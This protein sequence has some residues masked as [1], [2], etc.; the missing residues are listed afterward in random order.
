MDDVQHM[1]ANAKEH[2]F[3]FIIDSNTRNRAAYPSP[4]EYYI[5][6]PQPF[7]NVFAVDLIDA[8]IPRTEFSVDVH[9]NVIA[10]APGTYTTYDTALEKQTIVSVRIPPGDY[11]TAT[12]IQAVN[13]RLKFAGLE[14]GHAPLRAIPTSSPVDITN[15]LAFVR[16]EP[17]TLFMNQ[18]SMRSV[19]GFGAPATLPGNNV[20]WDGS[21]R[22][23]TNSDV[24]ND[25]FMSVTSIIEQGESFIGPMPIEVVDFSVQ[26]ESAIRQIYASRGSGVLTSIIIRGLADQATTLYGWI[27]D[28]SFDPPALVQSFE[29]QTDPQTNAWE[30]VMQPTRQTLDIVSI[31]SITIGEPPDTVPYIVLETKQAHNLDPNEL[32][33]ITGATTLALNGR[34][35]LQNPDNIM[36]TNPTYLVIDVASTAIQHP[37]LGSGVVYASKELLE[38]R[39]YSIVLDVNPHVRIYKALAFSDLAIRIDQYVNDSWSVFSTQDSLCAEIRV[40]S[41][42]DRVDAPGQ[43]N[44]TG[45]RYI[46]VRSPNIEQHMHRD[47]AVA[48]DGMTPGLGMVP[49]GGN[50]GGFR[51]ERLNFLQYEGRRFHPIGKLHGIDIRLE[52]SNGR[53]YNSQGIDHTILLCIKMYGPGTSTAIPKTLYP[54]YNADR[55]E[56]LIQQLERERQTQCPPFS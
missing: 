52:T 1:I 33:T 42:G 39:E 8:T 2:S 4:S 43:C 30:G 26:L 12:L 20:N 49:M 37:D 41:I 3:M 40:T 25:A 29:V 47:L 7:K 23:T 10:Y 55:R 50:T 31:T 9:S 27:E 44:L 53:V 6:F 21:L 11:N 54:N 15:T 38:G 13:E 32:I 34:W 14:K 22:Y 17:F 18:S 5:P 35:V 36:S 24:S 28:M 19:L 48:F 45:E 46:C 51:Q 16:S 56:M